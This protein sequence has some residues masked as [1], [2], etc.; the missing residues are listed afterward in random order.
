MTTRRGFLFAAAGGAAG[1][2]GAKRAE[3]LDCA[4]PVFDK[5][6]TGAKNIWACEIAK[7]VYKGKTPKRYKIKIL[8]RLKDGGL[9]PK[10]T[11]FELP[12]FTGWDLLTY[13][14]GQVLLFFFGDRINVL[15][16]I[17]IVL[18]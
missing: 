9:L 17:P 6:V 15:C 10:A 1:L 5:Q 14:K 12:A 3:A 16:N 7:V 11:H 2:A 8:K 4:L 18:R 13:K